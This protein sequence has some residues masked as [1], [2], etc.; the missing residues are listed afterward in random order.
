MCSRYSMAF[1]APGCMAAAGEM[2]RCDRQCTW[3]LLAAGKP[4]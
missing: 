1:S 3:L 2:G 4:A